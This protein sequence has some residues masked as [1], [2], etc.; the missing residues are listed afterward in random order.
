MVEENL[1]TATTSAPCVGFALWR[2]FQLASDRNPFG[3]PGF[4]A[5]GGGM[6]ASSKQHAPVFVPANEATVPSSFQERV[7]GMGKAHRS[8]TGS[9]AGFAA[10]G[11]PA[12]RVKGYP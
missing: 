12:V 7:I 5:S 11:T 6:V 4:G 9:I 10:L 8:R 1:H 3:G 2:Y